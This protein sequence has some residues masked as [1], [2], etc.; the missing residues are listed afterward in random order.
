MAPTGTLLFLFVHT[1][2]MREYFFLRALN[3]DRRPHIIREIRPGDKKTSDVI[4]SG[5]VRMPGRGRVGAERLAAAD[6][7]P[8]TPETADALAEP[9]MRPLP[10][11]LQ[12]IERG[13]FR[14]WRV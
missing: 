14:W 10:R 12:Y 5:P 6:A 8:E 9:N 4:Q 3:A 7:A 2:D 1:V 13:A 11:S